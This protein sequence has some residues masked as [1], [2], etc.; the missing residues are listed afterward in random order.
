MQI[1]HLQVK[2]YWWTKREHRGKP[3]AKVLS[4][5]VQAGRKIPPLQFAPII[6]RWNKKKMVQVNWLEWIVLRCGQN[7]YRWKYKKEHRGGRGGWREGRR[8]IGEKETF[9]EKAIKLI[10]D[11]PWGM[12]PQVCSVCMCLFECVCVCVCVCLVV[13]VQLRNAILGPRTSAIKQLERVK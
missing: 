3:V 7:W 13:T 12:F 2:Y 8:L 6:P 9:P 11:F 5:V 4:R 10:D 1:L